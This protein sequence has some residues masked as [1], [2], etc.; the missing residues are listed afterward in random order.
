MSLTGSLGSLPFTSAVL[1]ESLL[2]VAR[3][4]CIPGDAVP[5]I[6]KS[7]TEAEARYA[8][9]PLLSQIPS[10]FNLI[11]SQYDERP[12]TGVSAQSGSSRM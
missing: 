9:S 7:S 5:T 12:V 2:Y 8:H 10:P 3:R 11:N 6:P 4:M 1:D